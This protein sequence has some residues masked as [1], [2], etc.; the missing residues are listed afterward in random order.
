[1]QQHGLQVEVKADERRLALPDDQAI[2]L[3][4]SVRELL[5]NVVKHAQ[6]E[7]AS[8][9]VQVTAEDVLCIQVA[10]EGRGFD[11]N[12][13]FFGDQL[14]S[15]YG[16]FSIRERM[17]VMG[18]SLTLHS[19]PGQGTRVTIAIPYAREAGGSDAAALANAP[20]GSGLGSAPGP[21]QLKAGI[22]RVVLVDDHAMVR[23]GLRSILD[24][25]EDI[26]IVGEAGNGL[27]AV[28]LAGELK[29]HVVVMDL[30]MPIMDGIEATRRIKQTAPS[31]VVIGLS[32]RNDREAEEAMRQ[33]GASGYLTKESAA[34]QLHQAICTLLQDAPSNGN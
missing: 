17:V 6:S 13:V 33:A 34:E 5:M 1:M 26:T 20:Q 14:S 7:Q 22:V 8:I 24:S 9:T 11:S 29:P 10:D 2:L 19:A 23:Q 27:D 4:Q 12:A 16:L 18:G 15:R 32:V 25:Y 31:V 3:Y 28:N 30:N 21:K